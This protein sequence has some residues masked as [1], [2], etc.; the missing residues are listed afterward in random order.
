MCEN[1]PDEPQDPTPED[2]DPEL[3][4]NP[5]PEDPYIGATRLSKHMR[6]GELSIEVEIYTPNGW[7]SFEDII[8]GNITGG[9]DST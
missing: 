5:I 2:V 6:D 9:D 3:N 1:Q 8:K 7:L 4:I